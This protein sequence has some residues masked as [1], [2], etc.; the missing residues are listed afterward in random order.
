MMRQARRPRRADLHRLARE[1]RA[2]EPRAR[3]ELGHPRRPSPA[4][5]TAVS[6]TP[7]PRSTR[8]GASSSTVAMEDAVT[9]GCRFTGLARSGPSVMRSVARA[10][11]ARSTY[12]SRRRSWESGW[13]AASQPSCSARR[14][15]AANAS[16]ERESKR[17]RPKRGSPRRRP[18]RACPACRPARSSAS[19]RARRPAAQK[20]GSAARPSSVTPAPWRQMHQESGCEAARLADPALRLRRFA[21]PD[22]E[23]A[24]P[25]HG[26]RRRR[27]LG[28]RGQVRAR[29]LGGERVRAPRRRRATQSRIASRYSRL[30]LRGALGHLL[31]QLAGRAVHLPEALVGAGRL[32]GPHDAP[33]LVDPHR[34]RHVHDAVELGQPMLAIDQRRDRSASPPR[35]TAADRPRGCP[36]PP[37]SPRSHAPPAPRGAPATRAGRDGTLTRRPR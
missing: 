1:Q 5:R 31:R 13:S 18:A 14:T 30:R 10:A 28:E 9:V 11:A 12:V 15:S 21:V 2:H 32:R 20:S 8:P 7:Q 22:Q 23:L 17:L 33:G 29:P 4:R 26:L 24:E 16:T 19:R 35:S 36:S 6:P 25:E 27:V 34:L 37:R 3:L